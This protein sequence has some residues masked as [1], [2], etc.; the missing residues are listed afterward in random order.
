LVQRSQT[1]SKQAGGYRKVE[2]EAVAIDM[3]PAYIK[4]IRDNLPGTVI[5]FNYFHVIKLIN[6][7]T[8]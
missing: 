6:E 8:S 5:V 2:I 1:E 3:S 7:K 4:A